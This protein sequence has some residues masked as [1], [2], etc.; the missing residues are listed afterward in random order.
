[1]L[2]CWSLGGVGGTTTWST[3]SAVNAWA[4][5]RVSARSGMSLL[6]SRSPAAR[7]TANDPTHSYVR[8]LEPWALWRYLLLSC[9]RGA[10]R[11]EPRAARL[12]VQAG[13][14]WLT[15][16]PRPLASGSPG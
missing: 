3:R 14:V 10:R 11:T 13:F 9:V 16:V 5:A 15:G 2:D 12:C 4:L 6:P 8:A 1:M 7:V